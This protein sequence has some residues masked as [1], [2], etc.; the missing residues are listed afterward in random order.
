MR[1]VAAIAEKELRTY[2]VSPVAY[3]VLTGFLL[4][5]GYFFFMLVV[6]YQYYQSM[7]QST[8]NLQ[9]LEQITIPSLVVNPMLGNMSVILMLVVPLITMRLVAEERKLSTAELLLTSPISVTEII[10]GKFLGAWVFTVLLIGATGIYTGI[11]FHYAD[12]NPDLGPIL[13]GYA[14]ITLVATAFVAVGLF[15]SSVTENQIIAAI[16]AFVICLILY[17][18][19]WASQSLGGAAGAVLEHLSVMTHFESMAKGVVESSDLVYFATLILVWL[20]L[21][22][23]SLESLRYR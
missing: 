10:L 5:T 3:V 18:I 23:Q 11:V 21:A 16:V 13:A 6:Q 15:A 7:A 12:P 1:N 9:A 19:S 4:L 17:V 8:G 14:G 2:F 20:F 22:R